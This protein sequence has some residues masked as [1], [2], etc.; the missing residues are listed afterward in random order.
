MFPWFERNADTLYISSWRRISVK[1]IIDTQIKVHVQT[2]EPFCL[3]LDPKSMDITV[4]SYTCMATIHTLQHV[5]HFDFA[6]L[7]LLDLLT[8]KCIWTRCLP[9]NGTKI[10]PAANLTSKGPSLGQILTNNYKTQTWSPTQYCKQ[11]YNVSF[12]YPKK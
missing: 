5:K 2:S 8:P 1:Q 4:V 3:L 10:P 12:Q 6:M 11:S 7:G 9:L